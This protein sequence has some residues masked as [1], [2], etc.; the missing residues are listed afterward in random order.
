MKNRYIK[1]NNYTKLILYVKTAENSHFVS[2]W[3]KNCIIF[4]K[5]F[6]LSLII[7]TLL[8]LK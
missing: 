5:R 7:L 8:F 3:E 2:F 4:G 1:V 6:I